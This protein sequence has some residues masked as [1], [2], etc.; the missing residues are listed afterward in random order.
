MS[1]VGV[2]GCSEL[3][4]DVGWQRPVRRTPIFSFLSLQIGENKAVDLS[5]LVL[6][7]QQERFIRLPVEKRLSQFAN[8]R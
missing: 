6:K 2:D 4:W 5:A 8:V 3:C 1:V 7:V